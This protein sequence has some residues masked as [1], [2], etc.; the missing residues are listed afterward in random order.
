[1]LAA[2]LTASGQ[3]YRRT[4]SGFNYVLDR[5]IDCCDALLVDEYRL[6]R[7]AAQNAA[8]RLARFVGEL[9]WWLRDFPRISAYKLAGAN[10]T[11]VFVG[12]HQGLDG[13]MV[14]AAHASPTLVDV[15]PPVS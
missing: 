11:V 7:P 6:P 15:S 3:L 1:M 2:V 9:I 12:E 10:W 13:V 4:K 8:Y 5:V 14:V